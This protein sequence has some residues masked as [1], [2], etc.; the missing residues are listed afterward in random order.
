MNINKIEKLNKIIIKIKEL[1]TQII[2]IDKFAMLVANGETKSSFE[3]R[4][5][6]LEN[7]ENVSPNEDGYGG[8]EKYAAGLAFHIPSYITS[9]IRNI[10]VSDENVL[11]N[12]L[13][14][15]SVLS[16]LGILLFD[17]QEKRKNLI[18]KLEGY[19]VI[20]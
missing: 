1:D 14:V 2:E 19:G 7:K 4:I 11:K 12:D 10:S 16:I 18:K 13:S 17:K 3:L 5:E 15:N 8:I 6:D 20:V 9:K